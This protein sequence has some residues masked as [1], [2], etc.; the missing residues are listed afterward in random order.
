MPGC[1]S[2]AAL[3]ASR[4]KRSTS[5]ALASRPARSTLTATSRLQFG[6][7]GRGKTVPKEPEP[8]SSSSSNLPTRRGSVRRARI[9]GPRMKGGLGESQ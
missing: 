2:W 8:S 5:S 6:I 7:D 9:G 3:R 1:L 4:R